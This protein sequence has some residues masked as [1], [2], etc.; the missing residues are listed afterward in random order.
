MA[1]L[2][3]YI[4]TI[5]KSSNINIEYAV[6]EETLTTNLEQPTKILYLVYTSNVSTMLNSYVSGTSLE[7]FSENIYTK[8]DFF[9]FLCLHLKKERNLILDEF[10]TAFFDISKIVVSNIARFC[11]F[12]SVNC[13][14][15][16]FSMFLNE[17]N[18]VWKSR[19][20]NTFFFSIKSTF[21]PSQY[22]LATSVLKSLQA[23]CSEI[24]E[25][26]TRYSYREKI[27][28]I[29]LT[30]PNLIKLY[31]ISLNYIETNELSSELPE[32]ISLI[33][34]TLEQSAKPHDFLS[35][36]R[37]NLYKKVSNLLPTSTE[38]ITATLKSQALNFLEY[39][40]YEE[41]RSL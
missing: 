39:R 29:Y 33:L 5:N 27:E 13:S 25:N 6:V 9:N 26:I 36:C 8:L 19:D 31:Y 35:E 28:Q 3:E 22:D 21:I 30:L 11:N 2:T 7:V 18:I 12:N 15:P 32:K 40:L 38:H 14:D 23:V 1:N 37:N 20:F 16:F 4:E 10:S 17:K 24:A 41:M 34:T